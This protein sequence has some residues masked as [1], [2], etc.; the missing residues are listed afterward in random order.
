MGEIP[1]A[2]SKRKSM[3]ISLQGKLYKIGRI[4]ANLAFVIIRENLRLLYVAPNYRN[5]RY[6]AQK[7]FGQHIANHDIDHALG[8]ALC[9]YHGYSY[10]LLTRID[11]TTNRSHGNREK[12][13]QQKKSGINLEKFCY[14]DQRILRKILGLN[15]RNLPQNAQ[16]VGYNIVKSH[17]E[18]LTFS[19]VR[20]ARRALGMSKQNILLNCLHPIY[21]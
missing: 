9:Q 19:D 15:N 8:R 7:V 12:V 11:R 17:V 4:P 2:G 5:Y 13:S 1:I 20:Q 3:A 18:K 6:A 10:T 14:C 21:R 16:T